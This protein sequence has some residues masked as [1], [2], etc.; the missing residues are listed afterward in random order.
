MSTCPNCDKEATIGLVYSKELHKLV[1][2]PCASNAIREVE[3]EQRSKTPT[4]ESTP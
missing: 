4:R 3:H 2:A 1:C